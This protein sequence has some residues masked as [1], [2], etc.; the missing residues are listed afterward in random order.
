M[1]GA[2][3]TINSPPILVKNNNINGK[4]TRFLNVY[5]MK[6]STPAGNTPQFVHQKKCHLNLLVLQYIIPYVLF[7]LLNIMLNLKSFTN[8]LTLC[9]IFK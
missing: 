4:I 6:G 9:Y 5:Y 7:S 1:M 2:M 3:P 8:F